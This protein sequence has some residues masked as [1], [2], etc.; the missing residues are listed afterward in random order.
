[1][2]LR[3]P[4]KQYEVDPTIALPKSTYERRKRSFAEVDE[5]IHH[6]HDGDVESDQEENT[7][8]CC[9]DEPNIVNDGNDTDNSDCQVSLLLHFYPCCI[10][11]PSLSY[12][13]VY[14]VYNIV[15]CSNTC[16]RSLHFCAHRG[17]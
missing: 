10:Q 7:R 17:P 3:G 14:Y 12:A 1:M 13:N 15:I 6:G 8:I 5:D 16:Q 9:E 4:Y 2:P 11:T